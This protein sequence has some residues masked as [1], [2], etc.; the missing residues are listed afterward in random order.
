MG[1]S[2][3]KNEEKGEEKVSTE[4]LK[5]EE[6]DQL[7]NEGTHSTEILMKKEENLSN[8]N[9]RLTL[10]PRDQDLVQELATDRKLV[11]AKTENIYE[12]FICDKCGLQVKS[13]NIYLC[14]TCQY[15]YGLCENCLLKSLQKREEAHTH[16]ML[17]VP[18]TFYKPYNISLHH[19]I[20]Y[21]D[22]DRT[23]QLLACHPLTTQLEIY[24]KNQQFQIYFKN[25]LYIDRIIS[26]LVNID[27]VVDLI[28]MI[29]RSSDKSTLVIKKDKSLPVY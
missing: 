8:S 12:V 13:S 21:A 5:N 17:C 16:K 18:N 3:L 11:I 23:I 15:D 25:S 2:N 22:D 19:D 29:I 9:N 20:K 10:E 28:P 14:E 6:V 27:I 24:R 1:N 26:N 7:M 4:S